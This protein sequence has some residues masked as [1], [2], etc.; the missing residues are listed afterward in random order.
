MNIGRC[1]RSDILGLLV[2]ALKRLCGF[3]FPPCGI[4]LPK[5]EFKIYHQMMRSQ[6]E[7]RRPS[8][9]PATQRHCWQCAVPNM[10]LRKATFVVCPQGSPKLSTA[11]CETLANTSWNRVKSSPRSSA[12]IAKSGADKRWCLL[13]DTK[14]SGGSHA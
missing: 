12:R 11:A 13:Q 10:Q 6:R 4:Q 8:Q 3:S 1:G 5:E 7:S 2:P 9:P 14:G